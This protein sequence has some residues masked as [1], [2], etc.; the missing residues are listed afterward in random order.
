VGNRQRPGR[1]G[2]L[3]CARCRRHKRGA[4]VI[5]YCIVILILKAPCNTLLDDPDGPCI[6]CRK[7]GQE[8][9]CGVRTYPS[10]RLLAV[11]RH[12]DTAGVED[13]QQMVDPF[14]PSL[15]LFFK[16]QNSDLLNTRHTMV[17]CG[18]LSP[19]EQATHIGTEPDSLSALAK[20]NDAQTLEASRHLKGIKPR[21]AS[22]LE[23]KEHEFG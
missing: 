16:G 19:S 17:T 7:A 4:R 1:R 9:S 5:K 15:T 3:K 10:G 6:P 18:Q 13:I 12:W 14:L 23:G 8:M 22:I 2:A 20:A 11:P 21:I